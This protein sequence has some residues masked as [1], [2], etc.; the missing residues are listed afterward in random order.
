M[1]YHKMAGHTGN[2]KLLIHYFHESLIGSIA[3]WY[4]KLDRDQIHTWTDLVKAFLAQYDHV[5]DTAPDYMSLMTMEKKK[6]LRITHRDGVTSLL[7]FSL[8]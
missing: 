8:I 2:D 6:V 4:I 5:V 3:K 1:F 7:R